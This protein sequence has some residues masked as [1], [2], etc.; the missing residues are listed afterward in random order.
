L[1]ISGI[2]K[3]DAWKLETPKL[4]ACIMREGI[5]EAMVE[6]SPRKQIEYLCVH[7]PR[8]VISGLGVW[9]GLQ[10]LSL[11][12]SELATRRLDWPKAVQLPALE[13]IVIE[14]VANDLFLEELSGR[15]LEENLQRIVSPDI[16]PHL[17]CVRIHLSFMIGRISSFELCI[18]FDW[19]KSCVGHGLRIEMLQGS[20]ERSGNEWKTLSH[21]RL[22]DVL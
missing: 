12:Y 8:M 18:R 5:N 14:D 4:Q 1:V 16:F 6:V 22:N 9:R 11:K 21:D 20:M 2:Y 17:Q 13:C 15:H 7:R 19:L 10:T 3:V